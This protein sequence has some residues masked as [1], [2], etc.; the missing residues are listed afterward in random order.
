MSEATVYTA[1]LQVPCA[2]DDLADLFAVSVASVAMLENAVAISGIRLV[3]NADGFGQ[4]ESRN[5]GVLAAH[6]QGIVTSTSVLGNATNP[7]AIRDLLVAAPGLG[8]GVL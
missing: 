7:K 4:S 5:R 6:C 3:V 8:V 1:I 2:M